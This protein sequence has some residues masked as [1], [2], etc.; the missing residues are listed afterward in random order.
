MEDHLLLIEDDEAIALMYRMALE[1]AGWSVRV[2]PD[3]ERGL[4]A[5]LEEPPSIV[6]LDIM[7]PGL[8]GLEVLRR[9]RTAPA[10]RSCGVVVLSN[11]AGL[12]HSVDEASG[13]GIL[14]WMVKSRTTPRELVARLRGFRA[15]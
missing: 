15:G 3:G 7:L 10:T 12:P 13:L 5:A 8:D 14:D 6:L 4:A 2:E 9:L 11:S 1:A